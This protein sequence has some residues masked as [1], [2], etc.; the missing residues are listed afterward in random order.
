MV[1]GKDGSQQLTNQTKTSA[2]GQSTKGQIL[3]VIDTNFFIDHLSLVGQLADVAAGNGI[4]I[5]VPWIVLQELDG[6]KASNRNAASQGEWWQDSSDNVGVVARNSSRFL[7]SEIKRE[8]SPF[9]FQKRSE[10]LQYEHINDDKILDCC[11]YFSEKYQLPVVVLTKDRNL[12]IKARVNSCAVCSGAYLSVDNLVSGIKAAA[13]QVQP[14]ISKNDNISTTKPAPTEPATISQRAGKTVTAP[15]TTS[16]ESGTVR[17]IAKPKSL[18]QAGKLAQAP[19]P[20]PQLQS[21]SI[22]EAQS[23]SQSVKHSDEDVANVERSAKRAAKGPGSGKIKASTPSK[24]TNSQL[25]RAHVRADRSRRHSSNLKNS[26]VTPAPFIQQTKM[27]SWDNMPFTFAV[28]SNIPEVDDRINSLSAD[29]YQGITRRATNNVPSVAAQETDRMDTDSEYEA[30]NDMHKSQAPSLLQPTPTASATATLSAVV[31]LGS[32]TVAVQANATRSSTKRP[33]TPDCADQPVLIIMDELPLKIKQAR[34]SIAQRTATSVSEDIVQYMCDMKH[35]ALTSLLMERL[36]KRDIAALHLGSL[37]TRFDAP[38]WRTCTAMLT[39][40]LYYWSVLKQVLPRGLDTAIRR[41]IP[42]IMYIEGVQSCPQLKHPLPPELRIT[43]F[44]HMPHSNQETRDA[45]IVS[46]TKLLVQ[47][48]K[49][50]LAQC[51]LVENDVQERQRQ[52][53]MSNWITWQSSKA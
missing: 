32:G 43:P 17:R 1:L 35:C 6:L 25:M 40:V 41:S 50:I 42:W 26:S 13:G 27:V 16:T 4:F 7:E 44:A 21:Q 33:K 51:V 2:C 14:A 46:E 53:L 19:L 18:K 52:K 36:E 38:P 28:P 9:L 24:L 47:L 11:L 3:A 23:H 45:E 22:H 49:R 30:G 39:V 5:V 31:D 20:L 34:Q 8:D 37:R 29:Q 15:L 48:A 12:G 10:Y